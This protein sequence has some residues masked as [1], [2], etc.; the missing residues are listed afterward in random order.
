MVEQAPSSLASPPPT[1]PA[2]GTS[3]RTFPR[4]WQRASSQ[5]NPINRLFLMAKSTGGDR[6]V[7]NLSALNLRITCPTFKMQTVAKVRNSVPSGALFTSIDLSDAFHHLPIHPRFQ[8]Y[9]AFTHKG[10]LFFFQAM[11]FEINIGPRILVVSLINK[12]DPILLDQ[13]PTRAGPCPNSSKTSL[14][15]CKLHS[16]TLRARHLLGHLNA[17]ADSLSLSHPI[18][19]EWSLSQLGF[20]QLTAQQPR[21][22]IDLFTHKWN[23]KLPTFGCPFPFPTAT[24]VDALAAEWNQWERIYLFPPPDLIQTCVQNLGHFEGTALIVA[25]SLPSAPWWPEFQ[26]A[27]ILLEEDLDVGQWVQGEWLQVREMS[28]Y[29]FH[30]YSFCRGSI[31]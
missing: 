7:I 14:S 30:A 21:P 19:A 3:H 25:P 9:L 13:D 27:C 20:Q 15:L 10:K 11:P 24:V 8:K 16:W 12:Q 31:P 17:W 2:G 6:V 1:P 29:L 23:A 18:R 22:Q 26:E 4:C 5:N 28:S